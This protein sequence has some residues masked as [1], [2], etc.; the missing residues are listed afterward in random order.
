MSGA[1]E[2]GTLPREG[3]EL[4]WW[5]TGDPAGAPLVLLHGA[6]FDHRTWDAQLAAFAA[7]GHRVVTFDARC[8]GRSR[9][10]PPFRVAD[11]VDDVLALLDALGLPSAV[12]IGQSMGGNVAQD[13]VARAPERVRA[14]VALGCTCN[15]LGVSRAE[16]L[17]GR[18]ALTG[19]RW[20]PRGLYLRQVAQG[21]ARTPAARAL[22]AEMIEPIPTAEAA[23]MTWALV[24]NVRD[25]PGYRVPV[26][27]LL[28]RGE[29]DRLGNIAKAMPAWAQR[30]GAREVVLPGAGHAANQDDPAAFDRVVL[31]FLAELPPA[32]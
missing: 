11:A 31:E 17:L 29:G 7:A 8:H 28:V 20:Y 30:D 16:L 19:I 10:A 14:L 2:H 23:A 24:E 25:E 27:L 21:T 13:V 18:L 6:T 1:T 15:T 22:I 12:L 4:H 3:V 5:A 26:P 32:G 9:P